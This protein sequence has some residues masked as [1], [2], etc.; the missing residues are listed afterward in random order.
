[1]TANV[2]KRKLLLRAKRKRRIGAKIHGVAECPRV[3]FFKSNRTLYVQAIEDVNATTF[4]ASSGKA[5]GLKANKEGAL[6][7]AKDFAAKLKSK[8]INR[9]IFDRNGY[10]YHG[11]VLTFADGLREN[12]ISL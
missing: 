11:V 7:L 1:M 6:N 5:L 4:C 9:V 12:G 8:G 2:L 3:S 10:L